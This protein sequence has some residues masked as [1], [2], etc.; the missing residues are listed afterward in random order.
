MKTNKT[1]IAMMYDFDDTLVPG[2]IENYN[3]LPKI[4]LSP[5]EFAAEYTDLVVQ[6]EMDLILAFMYTYIATSKAKNLPTT[7]TEFMKYG[8][9]IKFYEG[10]EQW[11]ERINK[12][13]DERG[14][15]IEHYV[16]SSNLKEMIEGTVI[17]PEFKKV[18]ASYYY[19]DSTG[20]AVWPAVSMNYTAKTQ[21][22]FRISK[23][24]LDIIDDDS[25]N[26]VVKASERHV[27]FEN[28]IYFGDGIT[29][30]PCM[31]LVRSRGGHSIAV[32]GPESSNQVADQLK[33]EGRVNFAAPANYCEGKDLDTY[34][35]TVIDKIATKG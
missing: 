22:L 34:V 31:K 21:I 24:C 26:K 4:G 11:F 20:V 8:N 14:L 30:I 5:G 17:A 6:N 35:K 16:I 27:R 19:Y 25:V 13:G 12:Y 33:S 3:F 10:V 2:N 18:F 29:D 28:M 15:Q 9:G 1:V 32:Y 23:G 7:P